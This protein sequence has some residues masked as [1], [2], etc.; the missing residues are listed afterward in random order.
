MST[1]LEAVKTAHKALEEHLAN[2]IKIIDISKL[3]TISEYFTIT[4]AKNENHMHALQDAVE[5]SLAKADIHPK[6]VEG[7]RTGHWILLDYGDFVVHIFS[8]EDR[9]F[10]NVERIWS[11]GTEVE[12]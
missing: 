1:T 12:L 11:D 10:Y 9:N 2:D 7:G 6:R 5:E 4:D 3:T 8:K